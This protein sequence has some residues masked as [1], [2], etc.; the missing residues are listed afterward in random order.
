MNRGSAPT[1]AA[2]ATGSP[3]SAALATASVSRSYLT[4]M[5]SETKPIGTIT[6]AGAPSACCA[7]RW[8]QMSGSSQGVCGAPLRLWKTSSQGRSRTPVRSATVATISRATSRCWATYAPPGR[9]RAGSSGA[10]EVSAMESGM[11]WVVN[12]SRAPSR[13]SSG[14]AARAARVAS[15]IG[16]TKPGWLWKWRSLSTAGTG[17]PSAAS[18]A[19]A[20][21]RFSRYWRQP[22]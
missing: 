21:A 9:P 19:S 16:S 6:T 4:S 12:A 17:R 22:E 1:V 7:S 8:S 20:S 15:A 2:R 14:S 11:E 5:W 13:T 3:S 18:A 10:P